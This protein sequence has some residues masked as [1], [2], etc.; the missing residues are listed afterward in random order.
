M[1]EQVPPPGFKFN[2]DIFEGYEEQVQTA[3]AEAAYQDAPLP[4]FENV[5]TLDITP[6]FNPT[7]APAEEIFAR[8]RAP[9]SLRPAMAPASEWRSDDRPVRMWRIVERAKLEDGTGLVSSSIL[10]RNSVGDVETFNP[11][12]HLAS[13]H[14]GRMAGEGSST[15]FVSFS[16]DPAKLARDVI[17]KHGFGIKDGR[18]SVVVEVGVDSARVI[19]GSFKK[20]PEVLLLGGVAQEEYVAAYDVADFVG[21]IVPE[22]EAI[23]IRGNTM[24]RDKALGHWT[25]SDQVSHNVA[26]FEK[27]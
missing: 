24:Q 10:Q 8:N 20:A 11:V 23:V 22:D 7:E 16:T 21:H 17:L 4:T 14:E 6:A 13:N 25:L 15:P 26:P 27:K 3:V 19:S 5:P 1:L 18:D 12:L 9:R 2:P